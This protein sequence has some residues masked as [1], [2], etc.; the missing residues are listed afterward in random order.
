MKKLIILIFL[1]AICISGHLQDP[2][3]TDSLIAS[4]NFARSDS[5]KVKIL[6]ALSDHF[7]NNDFNKSLEYSNEALDISNRLKD[8]E[9]KA[10]S[11]LKLSKLYI[12]TGDYDKALENSLESLRIYEA[13]PVSIDLFNNYLTIGT[14]YDRIFKYDVALDYYYKA[15]NV[16]NELI[17]TEG[18]R[19]IPVNMQVLYNNIGNIYE[20]RNE[21]ETA[22]DYYN[23]AL[24]LAIEKNDFKLQGVIY[25]NLGKIHDKLSEYDQAYEYMIKALDARIMI[26]DKAGIAKSYYFLS[27]HFID[28]EDYEKS[29]EYALKAYEM[30]KEVGSLQTQHISSWFLFKIN[31]A[32]HR[33][34]EAADYHVIYKSI[35][36][37]LLNTNALNEITRMKMQYDFDTREAERELMQQKTRFRFALILAL[38]IGGVIILSLSVLI[39]RNRAN[40]IKL[41]KDNLEKDIELKNKELTTN[42]M[43]LIRKNEMISE[44]SSRLLKL[45]SRL[46]EENQEAIQKIIYELGSVTDEKIWREFELRFQN[47]HEDFYFNLASRFPDLS[48]G[49]LKLCAFLKLGMT[50]KEIAS[51]TNQTPKSIEVARTR[52]RKKLNLTNTDT[53]LLDFLQGI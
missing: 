40:R 46:K 47:V 44:I 19:D 42:V 12:N 13:L 33:Y 37:S 23:K 18:N 21:N 49:D 28:I 7:S 39:L 34:R 20:T 17:R 27:A 26:D 2:I 30:G 9:M 6:W 5:Q 1:S 32:M 36:D 24:E 50:S 48:K 35:S 16:H 29:E 25:N 15:L 11:H 8:K 22:I 43:Y 51:V 10:K 41:L 31:Y 53:D 38:L 52:L 3:K 45:K 14:L 4:Y